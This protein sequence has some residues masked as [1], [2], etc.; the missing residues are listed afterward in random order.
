MKT[1]N[2]KFFARNYSLGPLLEAI[3]QGANNPDYGDHFRRIDVDET[4]FCTVYKP[5]GG[6]NYVEM[7]R[8]RQFGE[9]IEGF[10]ILK[11]DDLT[12][13]N[14]YMAYCI[15]GHEVSTSEEDIWI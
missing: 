11:R 2:C 3:N 5:V 7:Y 1:F 13:Q 12:G 6:D 4:G 10:I 15:L 14:D 8:S 9:K